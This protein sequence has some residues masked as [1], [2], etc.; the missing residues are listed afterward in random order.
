MLIATDL[1]ST[2]N[3]LGATWLA[4]YNRDYDDN[5]T[6]DDIKSWDTHKYVKPACGKRIYSYLNEPNLYIRCDVQPGA[7]D[8]INGWLKAGHE[9][10][11]VSSCARGSYDAKRDWLKVHFPGIPPDNFIASHRKDLIRADV[12]I[13]DGFHNLV[14]FP[15]ERILFKAAWNIEQ[16]HADGE[17]LEIHLADGWHG[18]EYQVDNC[19]W[20]SN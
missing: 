2:L 19:I 12:L 8:V 16:W 20:A 11:V 6:N 13:D 17:R 14:N 10:L 18:V 5:L 3:T 15:G 7:Q 4:L 9:V 1:D